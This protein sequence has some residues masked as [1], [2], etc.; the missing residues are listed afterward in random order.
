MKR[1]Y[2]TIVLSA[3]VSLPAIA[4]QRDTMAIESGLDRI[5][6][7]Y[8]MTV[9]SGSSA[10]VHRGTGRS[11]FDRSPNID[12]GKALYGQI[13]GLNVYQGTG[14][15][16]DNIVSLSVHGKNPLVL[17]DG[18]P[19]NL[20]DLTTTEIESV[21]VLKD[22][23]SAALYGVRGANGVVLVTTRRGTAG[24]L[25]VSA[26][27]QYGINSRFRSPE[28]ADAYT[29]ANTLNTALALDGLAPRYD[30]RE[31][32][33][34]RTGAYPS[35]YPDVDWWNEVYKEHTSNYRLGL[36]F[37]GGSEKFRYYSVIDYMY[38]I[39]LFRNLKTDSRYSTVPSD[40]R[41]NV[42]ANFDVAVTKTTQLKLNI[43]GKIGEINRANYG[44]IYDVLYTTPSAAFPIRTENGIYGGTDVYGAN[45]PVA[46]LSDTGNYRQTAGLLMA[47]MSLRQNLD[48]LT[49][50]LG[51]EIRISFDNLGRMYDQTSKEYRYEDVRPSIA[52]DGTLVT[53]P[54]IYGLDSRVLG[55]GNGFYSLEMTADFQGKIDWTRTFGKHYVSAAAIYDQQS[56]IGNRQNISSKR[57]SA[58]V[59]ASYTYG[60]RYAASLV[61]NWSGTAYL[62]KGDTFRFYPAANAAWIISGEEFMADARWIDLFKIFA[63]CGI[64]G[65]DGNLS[66]DLY[67]QSYVSGNSYY[68]TDN[69][70]Y[71]YG[72]A[73]GTLPVENLQP[74]KSR[75]VTFGT[76][77]KA[78]GNRLDIYAEGFMEERSNILVSSSTVSGIIGIG[79][80]Q[81]CA[82]IQKYRGVDASV[83]WNDKV[84]DFSYGLYANGSFLASEVVNE[85]QEFQAYDYL[86]HKGNPVGQCYGLEVIGI[87]RNQME[88]N[89]SPVQSFS[90][91]RPGDLKYKDQNGDNIIDSQDVVRMYTSTV[92]EFY[93]GF[94][95]DF[96]YRGFEVSADFQGMT[97]VT[98]NLLNSP[99]YTP[100]IDNGTVS[101]TLLD[102][103]T[104][105]TP[106]TAGSATMPRLTTLSNENNYRNNSFWYRD[107]SFLK[108]RNLTLSYTFP[109]RLL[110]FADMKVY[111]TGTN[112]FCIDGLK[113]MDPEQLG[114]TY[115]AL[116]SYWV[117]LKFNF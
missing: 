11:T 109:K 38:D 97:G 31:L 10:Y 90:T 62:P 41:L 9:E 86:Y 27:F 69:T 64:S 91:V 54:V 70:S 115:P 75:K 50:G 96:G 67:R 102:H 19:R 71:F 83:S 68:F 82:G 81:Q 2:T 33:A 52:E 47:D 56:Y 111:V 7:G 21:T 108:L 65:W 114:A 24:K 110:K 18:F 94:G 48:V 4:V 36:T 40:V 26:D 6:L 13:A 63:S 16:Y 14:T 79:V 25:K 49:E 66:H 29:Y 53:S 57:Q 112:L 116:R 34:F 88:I 117:G 39:G 99:L 37:E 45:N 89:N 23:A 20:R 58:I 3:L 87:F 100:L 51:A 104:P 107:G 61:A 76:E 78:F 72:I 84:G 42:R 55:H 80:G 35:Q 106:E 77:F 103:E 22:A 44:S 8:G 43:M 74:E 92:P 15:T 60:G 95:L 101:Q 98:V 85:N 12:A 93:F 73:E 113:I 32:D 30:S 46:L 1:L 5:S 105:W 59:T 17:V 28:F